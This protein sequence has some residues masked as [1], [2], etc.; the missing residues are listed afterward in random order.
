MANRG[1]SSKAVPERTTRAVPVK[2]RPKKSQGNA[3][4][5]EFLD[6]PDS[7]DEEP[8]AERHKVTRFDA[9]GGRKLASASAIVTSE[10]SP[11]KKKRAYVEEVPDEESDLHKSPPVDEPYYFI[12]TRED[13]E[14]D[15]A[16]QDRVG[17]IEDLPPKSRTRTA[18]VS[19][20]RIYL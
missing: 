20:W 4:P 18:S 2:P 17:D 3:K 1:S 7:S 15:P 8:T 16:Y 10:G 19:A 5:V 14:L 13:V 11:V 9:R 12:D 6:T